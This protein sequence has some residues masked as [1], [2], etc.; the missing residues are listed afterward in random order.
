MH[1]SRK[2]SA[3]LLLKQIVLKKEVDIVLISEQ[4][5]KQKDETWITDLSNTAAIWVPK[6]KNLSIKKKGSGHGFV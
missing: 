2:S 3:V 5:C 1:D 6:N 4:Y